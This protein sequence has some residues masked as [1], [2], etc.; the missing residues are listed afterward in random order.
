MPN[1]QSVGT[2]WAK[3]R[4]SPR[5]VEEQI[6]FT[7]FPN[8]DPAIADVIMERTDTDPIGPV[9]A[10]KKAKKAEN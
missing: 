9:T 8:L 1:N 4:V 7:L 6:G 5:H 3:F 2:D 10:T